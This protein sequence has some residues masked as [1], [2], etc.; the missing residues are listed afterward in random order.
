MALLYERG[1]GVPQNDKE[2]VKWF[3]KGAEGGHQLARA[4][5]GAHYFKGPG[6]PE[7]ARE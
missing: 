1:D 3:E 4:K 6:V 7:A 2:A 5:L